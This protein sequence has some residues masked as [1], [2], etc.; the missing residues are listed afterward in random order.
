[1]LGTGLPT[2]SRPQL[3][4]NLNEG[5]PAAYTPK[6]EGAPSP[7]DTIIEAA[8]S[9]SI[10]WTHFDVC[11]YRNNMNKILMTPTTRDAWAL[12]CCF[13][14]R[15]ET[16]FLDIVPGPPATFRDAEKFTYYG[17]KFEAVCT[18][19]LARRSGR[20]QQQLGLSL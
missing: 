3:P 20:W 19:G 9:T 4:V 18:G 16:L 13:D 11:T 5:F 8:R 1:M 14:S 2:Y 12:D 6:P 10:D 7:V 17:Y 15:A